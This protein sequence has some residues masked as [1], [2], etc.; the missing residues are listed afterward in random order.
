M[1]DDCCCTKYPDQFHY[2][3]TL[4]SVLKRNNKTCELCDIYTTGYHFHYK[5]DC[6]GRVCL[7]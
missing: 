1:P 7:K 6:C 4:D 5:R 2:H 3:Y